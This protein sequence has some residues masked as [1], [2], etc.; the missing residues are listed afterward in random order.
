M[1][2]TTGLSASLPDSTTIPDCSQY[3]IPVRD[4]LELLSGKWKIPILGALIGGKK[5]FMELEKEIQRIT[6]R[7]LSKELRELE[8]NQLVS[9]NVKDSKPIT[10]EYEMTAYGRSLDKVLFE[11]RAWGLEHRARIMAPSHEQ[12][13]APAGSSSHAPSATPA[14]LS[15]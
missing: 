15:A 5:R 13:V 8:L 2:K 12:P 14:L 3:V 6:P 10:V 4:C 11:M 7:M 1:T 9:R